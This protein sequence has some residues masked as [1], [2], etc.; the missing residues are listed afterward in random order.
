MENPLS[1]GSLQEFYPVFMAAGAVFVMGPVCFWV[2]IAEVL[3][4][5]FDDFKPEP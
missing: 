1:D 2:I 4:V 5:Q 3:R